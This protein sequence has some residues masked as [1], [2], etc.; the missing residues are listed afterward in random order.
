MDTS[1]KFP[2]RGHHCAT[3]MQR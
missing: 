3:I 1:L 2:S